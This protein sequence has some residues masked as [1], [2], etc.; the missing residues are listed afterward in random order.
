MVTTAT[1]VRPLMYKI[2]ERLSELVVYALTSRERERWTEELRIVLN[3][4]HKSA[5]QCPRCE[6]DGEEP[7]APVDLEDGVALCGLCHGKGY[8]TLR[9]ALDHYTEEE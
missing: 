4:R 8:V 7:G 2:I 6:G 5:L 9:V 1:R 3:N